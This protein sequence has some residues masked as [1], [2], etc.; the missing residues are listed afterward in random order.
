MKRINLYKFLAAFFSLAMLFVACTKEAAD[1]RLD[2]KLST[3]Q[4]F[5]VKSDSA[6]VVGFVVAAGDGI[7]EKGVCYDIV[8]TPTVAKSKAVF[9]GKTTTATFT[10]KIGKLA[11]ATKYFVRA[12]ATT[13]SGTIYGEEYSFTTLPVVP[14]LTT[15]EISSITGNSAA[16]GGNVT[17][18]GGADVTVRGV[19]F[20]TKENPT[21]ADSKTTDDKGTG[22][23]TSA[24]TS[25]K[26]NTVYF[27]RAYA[28]NSAGTGYGPQVT[29]TTKVDLPALTTAAVIGVTKVAAISGGEVTYDG[30]ADVSERGIVMG[31]SENPTTADTKIKATVAGLGVFISNMAGL[32]AGTTYHVRAY[33]VNTA[34]TAYGNDISFTTLADIV[35]LWLVGVYNGW[36]NNDNANF[37]MSTAS[38]NGTAE[39]Y[40]FLK[41]GGLK[42]TTDH[43]W[44]AAHT[45]GV[46]DASG[47][48]TNPGGDIS[49]AA[50]GYYLVKAN[51]NDLSYSLTAMSWGV[52]G[53]STP[54]G[55]DDETAMTYDAASK[56]WKG[57]FTFTAGEFKFRANHNWDFN[58]GSTAKD[59]ITLNG[60]GDNIAVATAGSYNIVLDL[61][62]P[63]DYRYSI[64]AAKKKK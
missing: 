2:P 13:A 18:A 14:T 48:L 34:G 59:G 28:T 37:I 8:K 51:L 49:V 38:S 64:T 31:T 39:G 23:F 7:I 63:N 20:A 30:G 19:C 61:S 60:G 54:K 42:L 11:Y 50:D 53:S 55:W 46:G 40:S 33:A 62:R 35:K 25:L 36:G 58:F 26:G 4:V 24:L 12:Y 6:T 21:V 52:I 17:V 9:T 47:K 45:F 29:F 22:A 27:A 43:S 15:A 41:A 5:D 3:N 44:D 10:V 16:S 56:T 57:T 1:V 32:K